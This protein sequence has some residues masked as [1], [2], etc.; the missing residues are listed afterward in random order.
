MILV[1]VGTQFFDGLVDEVDRLVAAGVI[2]DH[3]WAQIGLAGKTPQHIEYVAFDRGL[4]DKAREAD[5]IITHAGTGSLCE[6]LVLARPL[7]AVANQTKA[8]NHQLEFLEQLSEV[9]DFCWVASPSDLEAALPHARRPKPLGAS[10]LE[11]LAENIRM[12]LVSA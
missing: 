10:S 8:G 5:L 11:S 6:F 4:I 1:T 2:T 7:I 12:T 9:Y 3:V